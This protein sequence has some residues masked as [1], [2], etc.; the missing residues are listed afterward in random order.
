M[1]RF[2]AKCVSIMNNRA[3]FQ[4]VNDETIPEADRFFNTANGNKFDVQLDADAGA[5]TSLTKDAEYYF[6]VSSA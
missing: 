3:Q 6:D 4:P 2:R 5:R 1:S